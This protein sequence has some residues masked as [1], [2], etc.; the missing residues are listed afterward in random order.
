MTVTIDDVR[1]EIGDTTDPYMATD[2]AIMT[3]IAEAVETLA[4]HGIAATTTLADRAVRLIAARDVID[5]ILVRVNHRAVTRIA[6]GNA[7]ITYTDLAASRT[8]L[9]ARIDDLIDALAGAP[10]EVTWDEFR[11]PGV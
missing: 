4:L 6:E 1:R 8:A 3:A 2:A 10:F 7:S 11:V 5:S 9:S